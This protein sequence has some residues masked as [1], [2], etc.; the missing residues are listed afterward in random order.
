[1][2]FFRLLLRK[3]WRILFFV[4]GVITFFLFYPLFYILLSN[5]KWFYKVFLLKRIWG[6]FLLYPVGIRYKVIREAKYDKNRTYVLCGNH[7]SYLDIIVMYL[8]V[9]VYFHFMG[10]A[11]LRR[12]PFFNKF[13][14]RMNILVDRSSIIGSH[15]AFVRAG[16]DID[17]GISIAIFPEATIPDCAPQL[18]RFKNGAFKLAIEK[19]TPILPVVFLD[20][21]QILPDNKMRKTG[22]RPGLSRV[23]ILEPVETAGLTDEDLPMLRQR[24]FTNIDTAL[25]EF[26]YG[27]K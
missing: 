5:D 9:P 27:N 22:G 1:M 11:E 16:A 4:N 15:R 20:N 3:T 2:N 24:V 13:F 19:Q 12:V 18:G 10:K 6:R 7:G 8:V 21:C 17:K 23:I 26:D 25:K 14:Q